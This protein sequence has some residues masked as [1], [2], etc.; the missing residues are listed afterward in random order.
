M[1]DLIDAVDIDWPYKPVK[2]ARQMLCSQCL[3]W[4]Q[5]GADV[6]CRDD[7]HI[8]CR[9]CSWR[10]VR[11]SAPNA[12][13]RVSDSACSRPDLVAAVVAAAGGK[14]RTGQMMTKHHSVGHATW[15]DDWTIVVVYPPRTATVGGWFEVFESWDCAE[16]KRRQWRF[17][18]GLSCATRN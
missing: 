14:Y 2:A 1:V 16:L 9:Q 18:E 15:C 3:G 13:R 8:V 5:P 4:S 10:H 6:F 12:I 7:W 17:V 11:D